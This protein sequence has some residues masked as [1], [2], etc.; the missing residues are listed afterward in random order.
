MLLEGL[1]KLSRVEL[2]NHKVFENTVNTILS[3][4]SPSR[5]DRVGTSDNAIG[6]FLNMLIGQTEGCGMVL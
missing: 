4:M 6:L 5:K 3:A 1:S 2:K